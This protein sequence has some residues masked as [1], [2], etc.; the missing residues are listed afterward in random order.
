MYECMWW[1]GAEIG[2]LL[3]TDAHY[4]WTD[5]STLFTLPASALCTEPSPQSPV[6]M[7]TVS[8]FYP[9]PTGEGEYLEVAEFML[10]SFAPF[11]SRIPKFL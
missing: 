4:T 11:L 6:T 1:P 2:Q 5:R 7:C 9:R 3:Y 10:P 8:W